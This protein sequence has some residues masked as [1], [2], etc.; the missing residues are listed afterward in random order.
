MVNQ[1]NNN[2]ITTGPELADVDIVD[3]YSN[4][5]SSTNYV[6]TIIASEDTTYVSDAEVQTAFAYRDAFR[7]GDVIGALNNFAAN[8]QDRVFNDETVSFDTILFWYQKIKNSNRELISLG[9]PGSTFGDKILPNL[10]PSLS[11]IMSSGFL[12][13]LNLQQSFFNIGSITSLGGILNKSNS[14]NGNLLGGVTSTLSNIGIPVQ[15]FLESVSDSVGTLVNTKYIQT[16]STLPVFDISQEYYGV[17]IP[18]SASTESKISNNTRNIAYNLSR[19]TTA[20]MRRNL[21]NIAYTM[22]ALTENMAT[23]ATVAHGQ[24][25]IND[26]PTFVNLNNT[27]PDLLATLSSRFVNS[28]TFQFIQYISNIGNNTAFNLRDIFPVQP[29]DRDFTVITNRDRAAASAQ[30]MKSISDN[31]IVDAYLQQQGMNYSG[32]YGS[33]ASSQYSGAIVAAPYATSLNPEGQSISSKLNKTVT[34]SGI[35]IK[36]FV[37]KNGVTRVDKA[38]YAAYINARLEGSPLV[39]YVPA[40]GAAYGI[41]TGS[42]EEWTSFMVRLGENESEFNVNSSNSADPGGSVGVQQIGPRQAVVY[43]GYKPTIGGTTISAAEAANPKV[44]TN[45]AVSMVEQLVVPRAGGAGVIGG[46][47]Y[48]RQGAARTYALTTLNKSRTG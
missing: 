11:N 38:S 27:L 17:P 43:G 15:S 6:E 19:N 7:Q 23:D 26:L 41:K 30:E 10:K 9:T 40:D 34:D 2:I 35:D 36:T 32:Q 25:L 14:I 8:I 29:G 47:Q 12:T 5:Q 4:L 33:G 21:V 20:L 28:R 3:Y 39:G 16:D 18:Y 1:G 22:P 48:G 31:A 13:G 45:T 24:N 37:D 44:N 42:R 46:G